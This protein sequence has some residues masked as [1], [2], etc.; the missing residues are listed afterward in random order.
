[1]K[2]EFTGGSLDKARLDTLVDA[3]Y[4]I[5]LTLLVLDLKLPEGLRTFEDP[6]RWAA[7]GPTPIFLCTQPVAPLDDLWARLRWYGA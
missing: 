2:S 1:M 3:V 5:A 7:E 4:A 6:Y